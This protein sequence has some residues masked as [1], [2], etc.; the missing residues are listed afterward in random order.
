[1]FSHKYTIGITRGSIKLKTVK[2]SD[3]THGLLAEF[4]KHYELKTFDDAITQALKWSIAFAAKDA[5]QQK[6][7]FSRLSK[8]ETTQDFDARRLYYV[9]WR[10]LALKRLHPEVEEVVQK[11]KKEMFLQEQEERELL[12][13]LK[14][15]KSS[16]RAKLPRKPT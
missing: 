9:F 1:M 13:K 6:E 8:L 12:K 5:L 11:I 14:Q 3:K 15:K 4:A 2:V 16:F 10:V 7:F